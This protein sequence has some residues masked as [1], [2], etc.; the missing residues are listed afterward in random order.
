MNALLPKKKVRAS[1]TKSKTGCRTC[2][3]RRVKCDE[4]RPL[5]RNC[6][7]TGRKCDGYGVWTTGTINILTTKEVVPVV[8][9]VSPQSSNDSS[10][11]PM[12]ISFLVKL[13]GLVSAQLNDEERLCFDF[14]RSTTIV[15]LPGL[16]YSH[17]WQEL[18]LQACV[19]EPAVL[20]A[21]IALGS[22]HRIEEET[23]RPRGAISLFDRTELSRRE[24]FTIQ[25]YSKAIS[26]LRNRK[27]EDKTASLRVVLITCVLFVT[28]DLLRGEYGNAM[29]H[30]QSG[31]KLMREL[32]SGGSDKATCQPEVDMSSNCTTVDESL[33]E[34]L[35]CLSVQSALFG[36]NTA[37]SHL[38][39]SQPTPLSDIKI[40]SRFRNMSEARRSFNS[41]LGEVLALS[42]KCRSFDF[43]GTT[44]PPDMSSRQVCLQS[45]IAS[46]K[47]AYSRSRDALTRQA[48]NEHTVL[49]VFLLRVFLTMTSIMAETALCRG[50]QT[51]FDNY[52]SHFTSIITQTLHLL[53]R[54][55]HKKMEMRARFNDWERAADFIADVGLLPFTYYTALKCR[56]PWI[57][58]QAIALLLATPIREGM[59]DSFIMGN[60]AREVMIAEEAG[61]FD[62]WADEID[63]GPFDSPVERNER[64]KHI[65]VLPE[66]LRFYDV[67]LEMLDPGKGCG[68]LIL[69][70]QKPGVEG[71]WEEVERSFDFSELTK[72]CYSDVDYSPLFA[73]GSSGS[74]S[75]SSVAS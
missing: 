72:G 74:S 20:H 36:C 4:S 52:T 10:P 46:W 43:S 45:A 23:L 56:V 73:D 55:A 38:E 39:I 25:E 30:T 6:F 70:R 24:V 50:K 63:A 11:E 68:K 47:M 75:G 8:Q 32:Q 51:I 17:F 62:S 49:G 61:F 34:S 14:F 37:T 15:K 66:S 48:N 71:G 64:L 16:F 60:V 59:W 22:A 27:T 19:L 5:C 2:K 41:V 35:S 31:W 12:N 65:P 57:R 54:S 18:V 7:S 29:T 42:Q 28:L 58:R 69:R 26:H 33:S 40:P 53:R 13:P 1:H 67:E 3:I 21:V 44:Y 9:T